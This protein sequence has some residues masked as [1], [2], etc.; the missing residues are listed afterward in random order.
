MES[1]V[2]SSISI[3]TTVC[4]GLLITALLSLNSCQKNENAANKRL[5]ISINSQADGVVKK[6][7]Y[8]YKTGGGEFLPFT[9]GNILV[10]NACHRQ[11]S[12]ATFPD[13]TTNVKYELYGFP[14][15]TFIAD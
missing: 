15:L 4:C 2:K 11:T 9:K 14:E 1:N 7:G 13:Q 3:K 5:L 6:Y 12:T 8:A 10:Y